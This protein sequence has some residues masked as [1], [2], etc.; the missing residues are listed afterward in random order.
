SFLFVNLLLFLF[1]LPFG[2]DFLRFKQKELR[3][4]STIC[5]SRAQRLLRVSSGWICW[6]IV[7]PIVWLIQNLDQSNRWDFHLTEFVD[8]LI[9]PLLNSL[10]FLFCRGEF[11]A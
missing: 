7:F 4:A 2:K 1:G 10:P 3:E 9:T 6:H 8:N 11:T 5:K